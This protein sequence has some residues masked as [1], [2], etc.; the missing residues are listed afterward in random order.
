MNLSNF[1]KFIRS[2]YKS[3]VT[4]IENNQ[5][6][7]FIEASDIDLVIWR[8]WVQLFLA[9]CSWCLRFTQPLSPKEQTQSFAY[10]F[11]K[12]ISAHWFSSKP[13]VMCVCF[14]CVVV[15]EVLIFFFV[16][17]LTDLIFFCLKAIAFRSLGQ[18]NIV[19]L[20]LSETH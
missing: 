1:S 15:V 5:S 8:D 4:T 14:V 2:V 3:K 9:N 13:A 7:I 17:K 6:L 11:A 10:H 19:I 16:R 20:N 12:Q 18:K